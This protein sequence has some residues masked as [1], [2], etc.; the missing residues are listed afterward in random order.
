MTTFNGKKGEENSVRIPSGSLYGS[1]NSGHGLENWAVSTQLDS[2]REHGYNAAA[3]SPITDDSTRYLG[4]YNQTV[5]TLNSRQFS[6]FAHPVASASMANFL[7][8][9]EVCGL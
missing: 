7:Q 3:I 2:K 6:N 8:E 5:E 1:E 4:H 9:R